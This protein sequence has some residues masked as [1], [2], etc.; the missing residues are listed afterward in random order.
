M[1]SGLSDCWKM[2]HFLIA[3]GQ[4]AQMWSSVLRGDHTAVPCPGARGH[5]AQHSTNRAAE[6]LCSLRT[7][8]SCW[9]L[10]FQIL[11]AMSCSRCRRSLLSHRELG[12]YHMAVR[13]ESHSATF[14]KCQHWQGVL[15]PKDTMHSRAN[16]RQCTF[17]A[18]C[19][20]CSLHMVCYG[21]GQTQFHRKWT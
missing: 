20:P 12:P 9:S 8:L 1:D 6:G 10:F 15:I 14:V 11:V 16:P 7:L 2:W 3:G 18:S 21:L 19:D 13:T 4:C 5:I 17:L